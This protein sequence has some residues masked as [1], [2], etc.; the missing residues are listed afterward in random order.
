MHDLRIYYKRRLSVL[1]KSLC[2]VPVLSEIRVLE[3]IAERNR[4]SREGCQ[5]IFII[6]LI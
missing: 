6:A 5:N 1:I 3:E 4:P 2:V